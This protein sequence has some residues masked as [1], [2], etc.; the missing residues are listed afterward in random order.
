MMNIRKARR[1]ESVVNVKILVAD[2]ILKNKKRPAIMVGLFCCPTI[3]LASCNSF[4]FI[5]FMS[6]YSADILII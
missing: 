3:Y 4:H 1:E 2:N 6:L 5:F